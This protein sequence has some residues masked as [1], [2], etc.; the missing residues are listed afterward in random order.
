VDLTVQYF[1]PDNIVSVTAQAGTGTGD[2][3][4]NRSA[5]GQEVSL[6]SKR[7]KTVNGFIHVQNDGNESDAARI[8][9]SKGNRIFQV[10]YRAAGENATASIVTGTFMT[11]RVAAGGSQLVAAQ[12]K[13]DRTRIKKTTP[14]GTK[15][16]KKRITLKISSVSGQA[17]NKSDH[18]MIRVQT[19]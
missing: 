13:P 4:Y 11:P 10:T 17:P 8:T 9:G 5:A 19:R 15:W 6:P 1:Q 14:R 16:R 2:D 3:I 12:I 7:G 18:A